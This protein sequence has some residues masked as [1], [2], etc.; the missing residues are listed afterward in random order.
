MKTSKDEFLQAFK[1]LEDV[2]AGNGFTRQNGTKSLVAQYEDTLDSESDVKKGLQQCRIIRNAYQHENRVLFVPT[3]DAIDL[4]NNVARE[5]DTRVRTKDIAKKTKKYLTTDKFQDVFTQK[6]L[7]FVLNGGVIPV[8]SST[9]RY[10]G[11]IDSR[12]AIMILAT[13]KKVQIKAYLADNEIREAMNLA[14]YAVSPEAFYADLDP[15][16]AYYVH[17]SSGKYKGIIQRFGVK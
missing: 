17:D 9:L 6:D 11:S 5:L 15:A 12:V 4:L 7:T 14:A 3:K 2:L 8:L 16:Q 10:M 13:Y 1:N